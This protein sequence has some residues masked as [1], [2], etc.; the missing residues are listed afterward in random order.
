MYEGQEQGYLSLQR[1]EWNGVSSL[2]P[3]GAA[4]MPPAAAGTEHAASDGLKFDFPSKSHHFFSGVP[5]HH[6]V[7]KM[8]SAARLGHEFLEKV[9]DEKVV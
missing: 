1:K 2:S 9:E 5:Y 6:A 8:Y 3:V 7:G 4:Y